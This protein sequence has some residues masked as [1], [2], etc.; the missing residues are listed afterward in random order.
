MRGSA[1][2]K[3]FLVVSDLE[4]TCDLSSPGDPPPDNEVLEF[5]FLLCDT[6]ERGLPIVEQR[7]FFC[8]PERTQVTAFCTT[9]TGI[10]RELIEREGRP[11]QEVVTAIEEAIGEERV[12]D[13]VL[14]FD[15]PWDLSLL[16]KEF[17]SKS[18]VLRFPAFWEAFVDLK[19]EFRRAFPI[20]LYPESNFHPVPSMNAMKRFTRADKGL[21][22][23]Q[24]LDDC[25]QIHAILE[26]MLELPGYSVGPGEPY[27][28][29][30]ESKNFNDRFTEA[31]TL[32]QLLRALDFA[33][34]DVLAVF[35]TPHV[36]RTLSSIHIVPGASTLALSYVCVLRDSY[37][38]QV[39]LM[40]GNVS[41][42]CY[43]LSHWE[44]LL[45]KNS[46]TML[47]CV[48]HSETL[49]SDP[50]LMAQWRAMLC[51]PRLLKTC[52]DS[53]NALLQ[54]AARF[55]KKGSYDM[56]RQRR[57]NAAVEIGAAARL[58]GLKEPMGDGQLEEVLVRISAMIDPVSQVSIAA[59]LARP[60]ALGVVLEPA[61]SSG[62][63][64]IRNCAELV[65]A[66]RAMMFF[67]TLLVEGETIVAAAGPR[68]TPGHVDST[69]YLV[70]AF[71]GTPCTLYWRDGEWRVAVA[72]RFARFANAAFNYSADL[73]A[74]ANLFWELFKGWRLPQPEMQ[75]SRC[76]CFVLST[77]TKQLA[78][79]FAFQVPSL[80]LLPVP[81]F[82]PAAL[83]W[84]YAKRVHDF[85]QDVPPTVLQG[86][87]HVLPDG[88]V[89][90]L[91]ASHAHASYR[92]LMGLG[93]FH[94]ETIDHVMT[95]LLFV[96]DASWFDLAALKG[97]FG[98][99]KAW[100]DAKLEETDKEYTSKRYLPS[101]AFWGAVADSP[102]KNW[103]VEMRREAAKNTRQFL[104]HR[105]SPKVLAMMWK[106]DQALAR[107][108]QNPVDENPPHGIPIE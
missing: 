12:L 92:A 78:F 72:R 106:K 15:G 33:E 44:S 55:E 53:C 4:A 77:A 81:Q 99:C 35:V 43:S 69:G 79:E 48:F 45:D 39:Y 14:C 6:A 23:H 31:P 107:Q 9:L 71:A 100:L 17:A 1:P 26:K 89:R 62:G 52:R 41:A 27:D 7:R 61:G 56:A 108:G 80:A 30:Y 19:V 49:K 63:T 37:R 68:S 90:K 57:T 22:A 76:F 28:P 82:D 86:C 87:W 75:G 64:V 25:L 24:G 20:H 51:F 42:Q 83:G 105:V 101:A 65:G 94:P 97:V 46:P 13:A 58:V 60:Q 91:V 85:R 10:T 50:A 102:V 74:D 95:L 32:P 40:R 104:M 34:A 93:N 11:L 84:R 8:R 3:R 54:E 103:L 36:V 96:P 88:R 47:S 66:A 70:E 18:I 59:L 16:Q 98:R 73:L 67:E 5:P 2:T 21:T 29:N 38:A